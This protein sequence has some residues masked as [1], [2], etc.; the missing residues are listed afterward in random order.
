MIANMVVEFMSGSKL[1]IEDFCSTLDLK[2]CTALY[3]LTQIGIHF[4]S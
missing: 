3:W 2:N 4:D 1:E